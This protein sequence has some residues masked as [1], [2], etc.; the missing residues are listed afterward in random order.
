MEEQWKIKID[1]RIHSFSDRSGINNLLIKQKNQLS[2]DSKIL[3][4]KPGQSEWKEI[5]TL[6]EFSDVCSYINTGQKGYDHPLTIQGEEKSEPAEEKKHIKCIECGSINPK[7]ALYCDMCNMPFKKEEK[8]DSPPPPEEPEIKVKRTIPWIKLGI[9]AFL[10]LLGYLV[11]NK[12]EAELPAREAGHASSNI[13][14]MFGDNLIDRTGSEFSPDILGD[15]TIAIYFSA[16]W[17]PPCR[18]FTPILIDAY[19]TLQ[20]QEV[21]FEAVLV[22]ADRS[23]SDMMKYMKDYQMPWLAI[24][25]SDQA[26]IQALYSKYNVR[27]IPSLII[28]DADGE[29]ISEKGQ[30]WLRRELSKY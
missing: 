15:K 23:E 30:L 4:L 12:P 13:K 20:E 14:N 21:P 11:I 26:T 1:D 7:Q 29:T 24:N 5:S 9:A 28:I 22:S 3:I 2:S 25:Y 8:P 6:E 17:C 19:N 16:S 10:L 18:K 27:G